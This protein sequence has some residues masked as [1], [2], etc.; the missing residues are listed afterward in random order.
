MIRDGLLAANV[1]STQKIFLCS[2]ES[3]NPISPSASVNRND[4]PVFRRCDD[5]LFSTFSIV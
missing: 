2:R 5:E 3:R 4:I 1:E